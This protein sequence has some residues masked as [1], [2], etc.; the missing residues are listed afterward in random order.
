MDSRVKRCMIAGLSRY[1]FEITTSF[2]VGIALTGI[3]I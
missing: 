3:Y 2:I 1:H